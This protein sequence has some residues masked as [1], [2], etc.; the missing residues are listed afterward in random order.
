MKTNESYEFLVGSHYLNALI[1]GDTT[2]LDDSE[3]RLLDVF[4]DWVFDLC[5]KGYEFGHYSVSNEQPSFRLCE[6]SNLFADTVII[7]AIYWSKSL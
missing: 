2:G 4:T 6:V 5:P 1:N 7:E 3:Q